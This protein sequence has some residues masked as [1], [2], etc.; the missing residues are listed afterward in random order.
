MVVSL[1]ARMKTIQ[2]TRIYVYETLCPQQMWT[3]H[4][5]YYENEGPT[6][7][8]GGWVVG[9][10]WKCKKKIGGRGVQSVGLRGEGDVNKELKSLWNCQKSGVWSGQGPFFCFVLFCFFFFWGGGKGGCTWRIEVIVKMQNES[11]GCQG[12]CERSY[13]ENA[14]NRGGGGVGGPVRWLGEG[15][16]E[17]RNEVIVK[18]QKRTFKFLRDI[19]VV[20]LTCKNEQDPI[21]NKLLEC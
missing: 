9:G 18:M 6:G 11:R 10:L 17:Q 2:S 16:C 19:L 21:Q 5:S 14:K 1:P 8:R 15:G 4:W 3:K 12:G 7:G 13:C 20:L